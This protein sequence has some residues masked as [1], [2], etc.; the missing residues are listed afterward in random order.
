[1]NIVEHDA[2]EFVQEVFFWVM[3]LRVEFLRHRKC[4]FFTL[5]GNAKTLSNLCTNSYYYHILSSTYY[6]QTLNLVLSNGCKTV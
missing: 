5:G 2:M 6:P 1:M 4:E 3:S